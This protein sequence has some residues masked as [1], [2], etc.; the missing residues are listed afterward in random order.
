MT[1]NTLLFV[2]EVVEQVEIASS[3]WSS[4]S[5]ASNVARG[6]ASA[7][8][9]SSAALARCAVNHGFY[10]KDYSCIFQFVARNIKRD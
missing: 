2:S 3:A 5:S 10:Y 1:R 7:A 9:T 6:A 8:Q 4:A